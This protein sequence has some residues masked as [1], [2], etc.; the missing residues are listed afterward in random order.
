MGSV[1]RAGG[2]IWGGVCPGEGLLVFS[3]CPSRLARCCVDRTTDVLKAELQFVFLALWNY[4][5]SRF[6]PCSWVIYRLSEH[7]RPGFRAW[8]RLCEPSQRGSRAS[9]DESQA[10]HV[11][12]LERVSLS[13][14]RGDGQGLR[15]GSI[16]SYSGSFLIEKVCGLVLWTCILSV[17]EALRNVL[18]NRVYGGKEEGEELWEPEL[19]ARN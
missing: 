19:N 14:L 1:C 18:S 3:L 4:R 11:E 16:S 7:G 17:N 8:L 5:G 9:A 10:P 13:L 12:K 2:E 6:L 15:M